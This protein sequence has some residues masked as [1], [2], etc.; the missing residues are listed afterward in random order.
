MKITAIALAATLA[1]APTVA[2]AQGRTPL[3][4]PT[5][6][7]AGQAA[8][9]TT[10]GTQTPAAKTP[11]VGVAVVDTAGGA[12]GTIEAING[13]LATINSGTNK[14]PFPLTSMTAGP[15][16]VIIAMT[17]AQLDASFV[18]T[19]AK[20]K[21]ELKTRLVAGTPVFGADGTT[22]LGTIKAVEPGFVTIGAKRD[23]RI[24]EASFALGQ[25]GVVTG[26]TPE[27]FKAAAGEQ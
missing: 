23:V 8:A 15:N 7:P 26:V 9:T 4:N 27:A 2:G 13:D 3:P 6:A 25:T 12:V 14:V 21:A 10:A 19:Q 11:A 17:K 1:A 5:P 24:P 20:A 18:E 16:G 22:Q